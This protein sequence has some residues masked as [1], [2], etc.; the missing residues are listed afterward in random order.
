MNRY[1]LRAEVPHDIVNLLSQV[2]CEG[3][4]RGVYPT[5]IVWEWFEPRPRALL[6]NGCVFSFESTLTLDDLRAA[7]A[8][9]VDGHVMAETV[10]LESAY[11]GVRVPLMAVAQ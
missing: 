9:V 11:T 4:A 3:M 8:S 2:N 5:S 7:C 1:K 10:A 6:C